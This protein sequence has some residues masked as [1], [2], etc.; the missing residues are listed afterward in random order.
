MRCDV[1][2]EFIISYIQ[3]DVGF[4]VYEVTVRDVLCVGLTQGYGKALK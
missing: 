2:D 3:Y 1:L 4:P